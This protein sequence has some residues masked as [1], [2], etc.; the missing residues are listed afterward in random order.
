MEIKTL[1]DLKEA[2]DGIPIEVLKDFGVHFGEEPYA[3]LLYFGAVEEDPQQEFQKRIEKHP[4]L[5]K[6]DNWITNI[7]K[8]TLKQERNAETEDIDPT[9][10][11]EGCVGSEDKIEVPEYKKH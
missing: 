5:E 9:E 11:T 6:V 3:Q 10:D 4:T 8:I 7:S 1:K 2:L